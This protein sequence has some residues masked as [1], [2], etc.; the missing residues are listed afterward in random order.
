MLIGFYVCLYLDNRSDNYSNERDDYHNRRY[1]GRHGDRGFRR[2]QYYD[3]QRDSR[4]H[5][6]YISFINFLEYI[7]NGYLTFKKN[8]IMG[9]TI[10]H[11]FCHTH[12]GASTYT[13]R[14]SLKKHNLAVL[15]FDFE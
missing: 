2:N 3:R 5:Q 15:S 7:L 9:T 13:I 14:I 12:S 4:Y 6:R 11:S 1:E 8:I 10:V